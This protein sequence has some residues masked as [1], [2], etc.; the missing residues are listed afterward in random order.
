MY[1]CAYGHVV[2]GWCEGNT[3]NVI[4]SDWLESNG[5][6]LFCS[7]QVKCHAGEAIYGLCCSVDVNTGNSSI[8]ETD[9]LIVQEAYN[10]LVKLYE[11]V[12]IKLG[13]YIAVAGD[14]EWEHTTYLGDEDEEREHTT[15]LGDEDE[16]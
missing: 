14:M 11:G 13:Y 5:I 9:K 3:D 12:E 16:E 15:Y 8:D 7:Y 1:G 6:D 4:N 10:K 2:Y